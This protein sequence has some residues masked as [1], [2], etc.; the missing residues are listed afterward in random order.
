MTI[1][2]FFFGSVGHYLGIYTKSL[3]PLLCFLNSLGD[4]QVEL[5]VGELIISHTF[6]YFLYNFRYI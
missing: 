5:K 1:I 2:T 6:T 4:I 3:N